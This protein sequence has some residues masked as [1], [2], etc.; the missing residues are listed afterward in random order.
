MSKTKLSNIFPTITLPSTGPDQHTHVYV[1]SSPGKKPPFQ[2]AR[3]HTIFGTI[4]A[5]KENEIIS[6]AQE[7]MDA[8]SVQLVQ[9]FSLRDIEIA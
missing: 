1:V 4:E 9:V 8:L 3:L 5:S 7:H 6:Q 2:E